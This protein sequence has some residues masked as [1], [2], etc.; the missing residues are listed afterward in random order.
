MMHKYPGRII[1]LGFILVSG[2]VLLPLLM[3]IGV[4]GASF[5]LSFL[6][7]ALSIG[8]L[9]IGIIGIVL[10]RGGDA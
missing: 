5:A 1:I 3:V 9:L 6:S 4:I 8:G 7:Y 2:G 10:Y